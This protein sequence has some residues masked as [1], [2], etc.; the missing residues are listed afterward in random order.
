MT[1]GGQPKE[2][3]TPE[4]RCIVTGET[5]PKDGL[6]RFVLS[7]DGIVTPDV[8]ERLPGRGIWVSADKAT[9]QTAIDKKMFARGSKAPAIIPDGLL[10]LTEKLLTKRTIEMISLARKGGRAIVGFDMTKSALSYDKAKVLLQA[11]DGSEGQKQKLRAPQ[12]D[13]SYFDCLTAA[14][15]G[16]A[17]G[18]ETVIHAA[19]MHGGLTKRVVA[20]AKRLTGLRAKS[21]KPNKKM[22]GGPRQRRTTR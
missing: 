9:L 17:F 4:R 10:E 19:L 12:G 8:A 14:E 22:A 2:N 1:R 11:S 3:A 18:R 20:E 7:P 13:A 5:G 16:V 21:A 6:I 15:L